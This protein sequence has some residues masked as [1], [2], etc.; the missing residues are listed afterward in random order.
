M[1]R[2]VTR[3]ADWAP[4]RVQPTSDGDLV[5]RITLRARPQPALPATCAD[6]IADA[7][8]RLRAIAIFWDTDRSGYQQITIDVD[9]CPATTAAHAAQLLRK[10]LANTPH[11]ESPNRVP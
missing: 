10:R 3:P 6:A 1:S 11:A 2:T 5:S 4:A 8:L 9:P 7:R